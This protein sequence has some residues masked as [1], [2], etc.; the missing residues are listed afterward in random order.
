[1]ISINFKFTR[2][3]TTNITNTQAKKEMKHVHKYTAVAHLSLALIHEQLQQHHCLSWQ[4]R[5]LW[6]LFSWVAPENRLW[7]AWRPFAAS[8]NSLSCILSV[9]HA[10][11]SE[12][13]CNAAAMRMTSSG[14]EST[15]SLTSTISLCVDMA[16]W[17]AG[18]DEWRQSRGLIR[19]R[20]PCSY[21]LAPTS[22]TM[23]LVIVVTWSTSSIVRARR[24][25]DSCY[26]C[27]RV[28]L[29]DEPLLGHVS[30][31]SRTCKTRVHVPH[32]CTC[33]CTLR[34]EA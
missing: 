9:L 14:N 24:R 20:R 15:I 34:A 25:P 31:R 12:C 27:A 23:G 11:A 8:S 6:F 33:T 26:M 29:L 13:S 32:S 22:H 18:G 7:R 10:C 21:V 4:S 16:T 28:P 19:A 2:D 1:M 30:C 17:C 3:T 5:L